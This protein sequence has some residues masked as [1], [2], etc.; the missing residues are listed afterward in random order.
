[1]LRKP[2]TIEDFIDVVKNRVALLGPDFFRWA[3]LIVLAQLFLFGH[4]VSQP[5]GSVTTPNDVPGL[6]RYQ[7]S[8]IDQNIFTN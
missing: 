2:I 4:V 3:N 5:S 7:T 1:M 6:L 8:H